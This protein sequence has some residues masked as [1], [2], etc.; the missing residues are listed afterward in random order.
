MMP[1]ECLGKI[2]EQFSPSKKLWVV[3]E[4]VSNVFW[5]YSPAYQYLNKACQNRGLLPGHVCDYKGDVLS[6][7]SEATAIALNEGER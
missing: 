2:R 1:L 6:L 3:V 5:T 4:E 7:I